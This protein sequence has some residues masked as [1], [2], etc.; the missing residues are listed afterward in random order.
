M[1]FPCR[2][3]MGLWWP[4]I[5]RRLPLIIGNMNSVVMTSCKKNRSLPLVNRVRLIAISAARCQHT[6]YTT[7]ILI[8]RKHLAEDRT[9][10]Q[11]A[12][13]ASMFRSAIVSYYTVYTYCRHTI[14]KRLSPWTRF[15]S[16]E[17]QLLVQTTFVK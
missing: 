13:M 16:P 8:G 17:S 12:I 11:P 2:T 1:H 4:L 5:T 6:F 10:Y 3:H 15:C 9:C 14:V 7:Y